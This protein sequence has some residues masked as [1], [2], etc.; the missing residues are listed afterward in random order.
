MPNFANTEF[1]EVRRFFGTLMSFVPWSADTRLRHVVG[2]AYCC[3]AQPTPR[4]GVGSLPALL[5]DRG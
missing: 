4:E 2:C 1:S 3:L 5:L